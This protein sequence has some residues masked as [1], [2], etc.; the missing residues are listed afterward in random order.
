MASAEEEGRREQ[1]RRALAGD[2]VARRGLVDLLSPVIHFRVGRALM[3]R[4]Q[5]AGGRDVRQEVED[6]TQDV[7]GA[8][9]ADD[10]RALRGWD[11]DRGLSLANFAGLF[12]ERQISSLLRTRKRSPW[13]EDPTPE[14]GLDPPEAAVDLSGQLE[15]RDWLLALLGR[16]SEEL[17][18]LGLSLF[19]QLHVQQRSAAEVC[20]A[21]GMTRDAVYAWQSRLA[22]LARRLA[23]E[24]MSEAA[25]APRIPKAGGH[26]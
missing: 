20:A 8:L 12:A 23:S 24:L 15:S 5:A 26:G 17:S 25:G 2:A 16:M 21:T 13:T 6:F 22:K 19:E 18:P 11:P 7:F 1:V 10:G 9:F 4:T 14:E 3:R